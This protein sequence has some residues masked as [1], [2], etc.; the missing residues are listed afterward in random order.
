MAKHGINKVILVGNLGKDPQ[1]RVLE[2]G[3]TVVNFPLATTECYKDKN[4]KAIDKTEWH[5][6]VMWRGLAET[7]NKYLKKGSSVY[8]EGRLTTRSWESTDGRKNYKTE[9][10]ADHMVMLNYSRENGVHSDS[11]ES[12]FVTGN[13]E[14]CRENMD[15]LDELTLKTENLSF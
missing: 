7:A 6:I 8:L 4:G 10:E 13:E 1:K 11:E 15:P 3:V 12:I 5:N 2:S 9:V 14:L